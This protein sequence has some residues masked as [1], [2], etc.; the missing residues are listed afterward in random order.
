[1]K[2]CIKKIL[3]KLENN[4]FKAYVVGGYVRDYLLKRKTSDI[5]ICTNAKELELFNLF[6]LKPNRFGAI[7]FEKNKYHFDITTF[8][9]EK[10]YVKHHPE[11][12][13]FV[14][15]IELDLK[16]RD[17]TINALYMDKLG[18][19]FDL[20]EGIKDLKNKTIKMIGNPEERLR[21]DP[22]RI[23]RAI[24]FATV[25]NFKL[26]D[27]LYNTI[28]NNHSLVKE[29]SSYYLKEELSLI[30]QSKN[31]QY[32]LDL[33]KSLKID[34]VIGLSYQNIVYSKNIDVMWAQIDIEKLTFTKKEKDN[35]VKIKNILNKKSSR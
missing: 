5:D 3:N 24:R 21:E 35:I 1:M 29:V 18:H 26:D 8:R 7:S 4:G 30:L 33:L 34:K 20:F 27:E 22:V 15:N 12:I 19:I 31:Y 25:L 17:F 16:R 10:D 32:G 14:D 2:K 28:L 11:Y 6:S 9:E 23:L 13:R